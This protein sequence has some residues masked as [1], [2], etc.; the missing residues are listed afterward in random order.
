MSDFMRKLAV[1]TLPALAV[2]VA[3]TWMAYSITRRRSGVAAARLAGIRTLL[4]IVVATL[5]LWTLTLSNPNTSGS[6]ALNLVPL[7][8]I[9]GA[10]RFGEADYGVVNLWGNILVFIPIGALALMSMWTTTRHAGLKALT[11]G[12]GLSVAIE[13]AQYG[14]GRSADI[15]DVVLNTFG[16]ILGV[17]GVALVRRFSGREPTPTETSA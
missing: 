15:D 11:A 14:I 8:E 9:S 12:M 7:R 5:L 3:A 1:A 17:I 16:V 10:L 6:R 4:A 2:G 13:A